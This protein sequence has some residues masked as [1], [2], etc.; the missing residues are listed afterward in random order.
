MISAPSGSPQ[1][2]TANNISSR[3]A[4]LN[5]NPPLPVHQ[6]GNITAYIINASVVGSGESL[7]FVSD[8]TLL[9]LDT[10]APY[11]TYSFVIAAS[12]SVG[13]GPFSIEV[14]IETQ[15]EG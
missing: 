10:L 4:I 12:T 11:T 15:E 8:S 1:N 2:L 13:M 3:S 5:W 14:V 9:E 6:N 7:Q